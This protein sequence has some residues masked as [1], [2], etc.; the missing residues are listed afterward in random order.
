MTR[1]NTWIGWMAQHSGRCCKCKRKI[2]IG[3][4]IQWN[5]GTHLIK[6]ADRHG[7]RR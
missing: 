5:P 6:C 4:P 2:R 3:D 1:A 7:C